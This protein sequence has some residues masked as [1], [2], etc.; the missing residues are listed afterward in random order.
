MAYSIINRNELLLSELLCI[1]FYI[2]S[3]ELNSNK[4]LLTILKTS[5]R[6]FLQDLKLWRC[7]KEKF[8]GKAEGPILGMA[9]YSTITWRWA[10]WEWSDQCHER[11]L[12]TVMMMMKWK[13]DA[14]YS[15]E[16]YNYSMVDNSLLVPCAGKM[17]VCVN[18][19]F[20]IWI[21]T[22]GRTIKLPVFKWWN[23][24]SSDLL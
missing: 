4:I 8:S 24:T 22:I 23:M 11:S 3:W 7:L 1:K 15:F 5:C 19:G 2:I 16:H 9:G 21:V 17:C 10:S 14:F 13:I 18:Y 20:M 12:M 6:K